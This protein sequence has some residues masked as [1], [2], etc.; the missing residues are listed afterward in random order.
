MIV[1]LSLCTHFPS[2]YCP[3]C[4]ILQNC[5]QFR[6]CILKTPYRSWHDSCRIADEQASRVDCGWEKAPYEVVVTIK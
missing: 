3:K 5:F 1:N 4:A 6:S 2:D